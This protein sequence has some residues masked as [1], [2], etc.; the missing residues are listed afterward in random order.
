VLGFLTR[1]KTVVDVTSR[2]FYF[3]FAPNYRSECS[4]FEKDPEG[5]PYLQTLSA[6]VSELMT[7]SGRWPRAIDLTSVVTE[8]PALFS[9][10][11]GAANCA[12]YE[13]ELSDSTPVRSPPYQ[14]APPPPASPSFREGKRISGGG[15]ATP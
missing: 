6:E 9:S 12:P 7:E 2:R 13:I 4:A 5:E 8:F 15:G 1:S 10:T 11:L 14:C 3:G